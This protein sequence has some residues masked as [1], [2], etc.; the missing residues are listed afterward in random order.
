MYVCGA[1]MYVAWVCACGM[2]MVCGVCMRMCVCVGVYV[3]CV[4]D[5]CDVCDVCVCGVCMCVGKLMEPTT[6]PA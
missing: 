4:C 1:C 2:Y 3:A 6:V 5:V